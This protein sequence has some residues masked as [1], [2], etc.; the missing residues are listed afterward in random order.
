MS[1]HLPQTFLHSLQGTPGFDEA[2]FIKA[3]EDAKQVTSIRF[4]PRKPTTANGHLS[5]QSIVPWCAEG[6]YL[7]ERPS[8]TLDPVFHGGAYYVQ[9][10]SSMFIDHILKTI[11]N[12]KSMPQRVLD[13]CAAPGGKSTL[14]SSALPDSFIVCNEVIKTRVNI[15]AENIAKWGN[16]NV[17]ITNND[18]KD[19]QRLPGYFDLLL[20]DAPCSGSG[21]FRKDNE[22]ITEWSE[23]NVNLCSLRQQRITA[24]T[25][26]S[27][28][29]NGYFIYSTC[30]Y[31][32]QEDESICNWMAEKYKLESVKIPFDPSLGIVETVSEQGCYGYRFYPSKVEGEGFFVACFRQ[33]NP[34][35]K[36]YGYQT[37]LTS[38]SKKDQL[39]AETFIKNLENYILTGHKEII[40]ASPKKWEEEIAT[41]AKTLN[42]RRSGVAVG[43]VKGKDFIPHH[44]LALSHLS[45]DAVPVV[46][47]D[48][49]NA[50][51]YLRRQDM[52][53]EISQKG[54][55]IC[56]YEDINLGW[57]KVLPNRVNNYYPLNW[58]ILKR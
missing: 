34:V 51:N 38:I 36:H 29:Q 23:A 4:N 21:L 13:L 8:F 14:L 28:K 18:P 54:W 22:A 52:T 3:H 56:K 39:L 26:G 44:E 11:Y 10:A 47:V 27:L 31:S 58:R 55:I 42:L 50:L 33:P 57:M 48:K 2:E 46:V 20:I 24:E 9:E 17:V 6:R 1:H 43:E 37:T 32:M 49:E 12:E 41:I 15:L 19:F 16:E 35:D 45:G 53:V 30:S 5:I 7:S 40:I 25:I